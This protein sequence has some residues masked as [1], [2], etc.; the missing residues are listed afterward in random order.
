MSEIVTSDYRTKMLFF[1][2]IVALGLALPSRALQLPSR[3]HQ[4]L[5]SRASSPTMLDLPVEL[6][7]LP[8]AGAAII[9]VPLVFLASEFLQ[10]PPVGDIYVRPG[11]GSFGV[12]LICIRPV[13]KGQRVCVCEAKF[14]ERTTPTR[15]NLLSPAVRRTVLEL[16]DGY[17]SD[18]GTYGYPTNYD[19]AI[20]LISFIN[21]SDEPNC[22]YDV[23]TVGGE[24]VG[25]IRAARR[26]RTGEE[27]TV[28]YLKYQEPGSFT[29][30]ACQSNFQKKPFW[31]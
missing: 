1:V 16:F 11:V 27:A 18:D 22:Y 20:P 14:S 4:L 24:L 3:A 15:L 12:G 8:P 6:A 10:R 25:S 13:P 28:D 26:L 17:D 21:H 31:V 19:Q 30:R 29:Y 23:Q 9:A 5:P 7:E 2:G